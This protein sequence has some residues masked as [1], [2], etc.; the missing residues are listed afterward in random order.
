VVLLFRFAVVVGQI[1]QRASLTSLGVLFLADLAGCLEL[2]LR[3]LFL[4]V[5]LTEPLVWF[6]LWRG[7]AAV[8]NVIK[9]TVIQV[10]LDPIGV[11]P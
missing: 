3:F 7:S 8:M 10:P 4:V 6:R 2:A 1:G 5:F 11:C 9:V